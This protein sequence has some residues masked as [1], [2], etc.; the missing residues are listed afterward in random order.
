MHIIVACGETLLI[1]F[2]FFHWLQ[3]RGGGRVRYGRGES[4]IGEEESAV[5]DEESEVG[6]GRVKLCR[7]SAALG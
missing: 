4:E 2:C 5:G 6:R 1:E 7:S 3:D